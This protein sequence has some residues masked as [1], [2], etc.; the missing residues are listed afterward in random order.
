[1]WK[2]QRRIEACFKPPGMSRLRRLGFRSVH[3]QLRQLLVGKQRDAPPARVMLLNFVATLAEPCCPSG[4]NTDKVAAYHYTAWRA[5]SV[6]GI[7]MEIRPK[8]NKERCYEVAGLIVLCSLDC[9]T[10]RLA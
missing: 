1:M 5:L 10:H 8:R 2:C 4:G 7:Q 9:R 6:F 3:R